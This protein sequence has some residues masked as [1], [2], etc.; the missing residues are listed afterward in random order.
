MEKQRIFAKTWVLV[1]L[2]FM[3][4]VF[5]G[6]SVRQIE[7]NRF[8]S[9]SAL[10]RNVRLSFAYDKRYTGSSPD[11]ERVWDELLPVDFGF[12]KHSTLSPDPSAVA[13]FHQLHCLNGIRLH[14]D[15]KHSK[16]A[17]SAH[18]DV[19]PAHMRHCIDYLRQSIMCAADSNLEPVNEE[20]GGV[21]GWGS[22]RTCRDF[23]ALVGW[24][25]KHRSA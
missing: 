19:S 24:T 12:I 2:G 22:E 13:A 21:T 16:R 7:F 9:K 14:L 5:V 23:D 4:G 20:L 8:P 18:E 3:T 15:G 1:L 11:T 25:R 17:A 10:A 6:C